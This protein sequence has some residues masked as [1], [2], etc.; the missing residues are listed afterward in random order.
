ME[1]S[2]SQTIEHRQCGHVRNKAQHC[3]L[4]LFQDTDFAGDH[5]DS[6]STSRRVLSHF[7]RIGNYFFG[8]WFGGIPALDLWDVVI[9]V[10]HSS[11]NTHTH[12][13]THI[14]Q[15]E[16]AVEKER[17]TSKYRET[18]MRRSLEHKPNTK[19]KEERDADELSNVDHVVTNAS[20][21]QLYIFEDNEAAIKMVIKEQKSNV[22]VQNPQ[23][24][25][26]LVD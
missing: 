5:K 24:C 13:H 26:R 21:S 15:L 17:S 11:K 1:K 12:T 3:R 4:G 8:C 6:K 19:V 25:V 16:T 7:H 10:L 20:S 22:R 14:K 9:K 23:S 18:C 2:L